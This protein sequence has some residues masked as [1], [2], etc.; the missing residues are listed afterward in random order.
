MN[1]KA[2]AVSLSR[3]TPEGIS[4]E[5][6][7]AT[8]LDSSFCKRTFSCKA[9]RECPNALDVC[10][11]LVPHNS[12]EGVHFWAFLAK[13]RKRGPCFSLTWADITP[14][15]SEPSGKLRISR[16]NWLFATCATLHL[17]DGSCLY[18]C[19]LNEIVTHLL[20]VRVQQK[21]RK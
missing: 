11:F 7:F 2:L 15:S 20:P 4:Q 12:H 14:C 18:A 3:I 16:S 19:G 13:R 10:S 6:L 1:T 5:F 21:V 9:T 17:V 8:E